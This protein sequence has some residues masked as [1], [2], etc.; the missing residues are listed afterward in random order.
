MKRKTI[1]LTL[2]LMLATVG[3]W[4]QGDSPQLVVWLKGGEKAYFV[5]DKLPETSFGDGLLT[6][7][8]SSS[9]VSYLLSNVL[10][11]TYDNVRPTGIDKQPSA[12]SV[13]ISERGESITFRN[14]KSGTVVKLFSLGGVLLEQHTAKESEPLTITLQNYPSGAYIVR[15]ANETIKMLKP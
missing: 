14:L 8:S 6:I 5:L 1:F 3:T 10:R 2:L 15:A 13:K 12:Y 7:K 4:A 11:F 9:T